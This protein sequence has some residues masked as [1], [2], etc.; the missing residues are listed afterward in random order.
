MKILF[1]TRKM[2]HNPGA[3][4]LLVTNK[5]TAEQNCFCKNPGELKLK[6]ES[7]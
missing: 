4:Y 3:L 7:V 5:P 6:Y 1:Y 2:G